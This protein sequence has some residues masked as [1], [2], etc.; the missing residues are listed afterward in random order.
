MASLLVHAIL[1][2]VV[3]EAIP[4]TRGRRRKLRWLGVALACA[5]DLDMAT[6]AFE[7]RTTDLWGHRGAW[8]S[9]GMAALAAT[10]VTLIFFRFPP[11]GSAPGS[12]V[13]KALFWR[14]F[15]FLLGAAAS[16]GVLDAFTAGEAGV[17]LLW[18]LSTAR[19]L[20]PVDIV[21]ACP[22][23][24]SEYFSHWGLLTF[25]NELL[26]IVI[27]S[28][29]LL[30]I[31][32][33]LARRPGTAPRVPIRRTAMRIV[34]WLA[35][36]VGARVA[37][38]ETFAPHLE[39]RIEPMGTAIA[40]DPKDIP[41]RGLPDGRL[42]TSFDEVRQRGL[43]ERTLAPREAPWSSS[44]FPSWFGGEGG[45]W[46]EGSAR[47]AYR[48][49]TGFAPPSESEAKSWMARAAS[50]DAEAQRRIFT[51]APVEKIDLAL[52]RLDFPATVQAQK[53]SHNGHPRYWSGRCNGVAA[54][55][56][57]EPEPFRVVDV[58]G[59]D[60]NHVRFH[61]N[62]VKSLLSVAYYEPQVKLSIGDNCNE[63]A[64]DAAAPCN[65]SPAVFL[66]ALWNRLGIAEHTFIVD[67]L[68]NI[69]RQYYVVADATVHLVRPPYP[70]D[71]APIDAALRPKVRSFVDVTIDLTL[72]STT[73]TYRDVDHLD[74]AV[75]DGTAYRKVGVVPVRMHFSATLAL[76]E[77][78]ELLGG[79][80]TG[81]PANGIDV[82]M[83]VDGPP[84]VLPNGRLE[85]ADQVPWALVRAIAK[86][87]VLPPP[88]LPTL[89]LRTDCEGC[90]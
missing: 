51:L 15:A 80:W 50:G 67:A 45:R 35:I 42:V 36:A 82:V 43:L 37:L 78:S 52:G 68:P 41:T 24:A 85:A 55:S 34:A 10:V 17:A 19:W 74:P 9:L 56:M 25:A 23:G 21:A 54:A 2:L 90:R 29:L 83:D 18:P 7:L 72:S 39:R 86:A 49:L 64:F 11:R 48:T 75:P 47:L 12:H 8:H 81:T 89:D 38:P 76:G 5:P 60:G 40:G 57:V 63:V 14:S 88:G 71:D 53:L 13:R 26:F 4:L 62:D 30:G 32:R 3:V 77:G 59:V 33:H 27:P 28:L 69:A 31:Y 20:S 84:K 46:S 6:F 22:G 61:P 66:L 58:T 87:S 44:F 79:R 16:H 1:P 65:M 73:L 70:P